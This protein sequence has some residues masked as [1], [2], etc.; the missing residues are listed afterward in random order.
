MKNYFLKN[1]KFQVGKFVATEVML[2]QLQDN[3]IRASQ[4]G[5]SMGIFAD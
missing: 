2:E 5:I 1:L 3:T 4:A